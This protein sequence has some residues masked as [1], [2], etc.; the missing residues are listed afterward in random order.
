MIL[1][2]L[3]FAS[4]GAE[5]TSLTEF[6]IEKLMQPTGIAPE[7]LLHELTLI[8][9]QDSQVFVEKLWKMLVFYSLKCTR[10]L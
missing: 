6:I 7:E 8:L 4:L 1:L 3:S 9:E 2:I 5:E 10:G